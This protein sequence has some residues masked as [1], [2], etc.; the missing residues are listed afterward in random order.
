MKIVAAPTVAVK[1]AFPFVVILMLAFFAPAAAQTK[2]VRVYRVRF[3]QGRSSTVLRGRLRPYANHVYRLDARQ[4]QRMTVRVQEP[5]GDIVF[6][7]K[8]RNSAREKYPL[9]LAGI[10]KNGET[11]W[12]GELPASGE[13][14]IHVSNPT[15]GDHPVRRTLSYRVELKIE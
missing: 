11:D 5:A 10:H 7:V 15:I 8:G 1:I 13:Y 3:E 4:G 12:S 9:V 6:W 14:E 2:G